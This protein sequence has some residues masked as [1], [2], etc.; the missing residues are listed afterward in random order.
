MVPVL[1]DIM[2]LCFRIAG[3]DGICLSF[4]LLDRFVKS[5]RLLS[6]SQ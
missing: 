4:D 2:G 3:L 1:I 6:K 5:S